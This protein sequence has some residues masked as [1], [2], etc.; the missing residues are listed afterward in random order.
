MKIG[1]NKIALIFLILLSLYSCSVVLEHRV[2]YPDR[3]GADLRVFTTIED[4]VIIERDTLSA[5]SCGTC[6]YCI[7]WPFDHVIYNAWEVDT[8]LI[9]TIKG[10]GPYYDFIRRDTI[11]K[12]DRKIRVYK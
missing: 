5:Y 3:R 2:R 12:N 11:W 9:D 6:D 4:G 10:S 8:I 1:I 7:K